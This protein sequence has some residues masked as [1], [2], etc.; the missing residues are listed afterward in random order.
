MP[1]TETKKPDAEK[2]P[3][4]KADATKADAKAQATNPSALYVVSEFVDAETGA[5]IPAGA[6]LPPSIAGNATRV[7]ALKS[8]G[9]LSTNPPRAS[10]PSRV[11]GGALSVTY[12]HETP[13]ERGSGDV[14]GRAD[15]TK[16]AVKGDVGADA[17]E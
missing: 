15:T 16:R 14:G 3:A 9:V 17:K 10:G 1:D 13:G 6:E 11:P 5:T 4:T 2:A 7:E 12:S 8:A